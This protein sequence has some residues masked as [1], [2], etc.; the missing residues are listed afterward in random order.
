MTSHKKI[1]SQNTIRFCNRIRFFLILQFFP[2]IGF[3]ATRRF[4]THKC[5]ENFYWLKIK[6]FV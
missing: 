4:E 3:K 2:H 1:K 5:Q 6:L